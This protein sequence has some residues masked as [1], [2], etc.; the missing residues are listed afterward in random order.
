MLGVTRQ[1]NANRALKLVSDLPSPPGAG[2][3]WDCTSP[4]SGCVVHGAATTSRRTPAHDETLA[5]ATAEINRILSEYTRKEEIRTE[6]RTEVAVFRP[7]IMT[8]AAGLFLAWTRV[9]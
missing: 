3:Y 8:T 7:C 1:V 4:G 5:A 6:G 9:E 2:V